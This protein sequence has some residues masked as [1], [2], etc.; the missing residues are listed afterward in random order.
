MKYIYPE[1]LYKKIYS[2]KFSIY[3]I[4]FKSIFFNIFNILKKIKD[5]SIILDFGEGYLKKI[6]IKKNQYMKLLIMI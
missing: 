1:Q 5:K 4:Y 6:L 3:G 2:E